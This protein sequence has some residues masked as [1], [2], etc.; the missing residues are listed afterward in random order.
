M[1]RGT[2]DDETPQ[3][4]PGKNR[5][6]GNLMENVRIFYIFLGA[7]NGFPGV[8]PNFL[9]IPFVFRDNCAAF[10]RFD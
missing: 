2:I 7:N 10:L 9:P 1:P 8:R 6:R 5:D 4:N 3:P